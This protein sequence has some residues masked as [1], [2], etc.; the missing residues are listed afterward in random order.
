MALEPKLAVRAVEDR[1]EDG[2]EQRPRSRRHAQAPS[3]P[4]A[5][6]RLVPFHLLFRLTRRRFRGRGRDT[7]RLLRHR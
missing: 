2:K 4:R 3:R 6:F 7:F 5:L 1:P